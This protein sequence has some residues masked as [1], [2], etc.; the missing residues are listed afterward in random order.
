MLAHVSSQAPY[1]MMAY[2]WGS[3]SKEDQR[4]KVGSSLVGQS[5]GSV[6]ESANT[7]GLDTGAEDGASP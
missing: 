2:R 1:H 3:R 7:V 6:D 4:T 5:A